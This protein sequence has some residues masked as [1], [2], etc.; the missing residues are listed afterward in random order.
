LKFPVWLLSSLLVFVALPAASQ[1]QIEKIEYQGWPNCYRLSNGEVELVVTGDAGPRVIRYAFE[2]GENLFKEVQDDLGKTGGDEFRLYGGHRIWV[3]PEDRVLS[4]APDN[5]PV[6]IHQAD[7]SLRATAPVEEVTGLQKEMEV[8]LAAQGTS[9]AVT[10]R[11]TN[12]G[13]W[14]VE[15]A[16][17]V[18]TVMAAGGT[19]AAAFPPRGTHPEQ[20]LPTN[21]LVMWAFTDFSDERWTLLKKYLVLRQDPDRASPQKTGL[22]NAKTRAAYLL[23]GDLF[24]KKYDAVEGTYPDMGCS[25]ETFTNDS[26][27]ELETLGPLVRLAPGETVEHVERWSL[28]RDIEIGEWTD[29]ELDRVLRPLFQ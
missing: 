7:N 18:L 13:V 15:L 28:H 16:P 23:G 11:I 2:G 26:F 1:V 12:K 3:A 6:E 22:F 8:E 21:P 20:L 10:H 24:V 4:Y 25:F 9:A 17:W 29:A 14:S 5:A 19:G 27:L